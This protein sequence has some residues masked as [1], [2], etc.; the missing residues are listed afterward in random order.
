MPAY[1]PDN[2]CRLCGL[3]VGSSNISQPV[4]GAVARFCC[5]GCMY[6][7]QILYNR[8][9]GVPVDYRD[10]E[11]YRAC[12]SAGII[13]SD[14]GL[15]SRFPGHGSLVEGPLTRDSRLVTQDP[16]KGLTRNLRPETPDPDILDRLSQ[17]LSIKIE[18][19]WCVACSWL[20]EQL[21]LKM[22]GVVSAGI[23]FFSDI[24]H[25]KYMPH[26]V[27]PKAIM[28]NIS[29]LGYRASPI[30]S[31]T[32]SAPSG[33]LAV[34]LGVSAILSMN[35]M[36]ITFALWAGFFEQI[37]REGAALFS[38]TLFVIA[39]P[40]VFYSGWPILRG[41][42]LSIR[43]RTATMD[44]LLAIGVLSAYFYSVVA[45]LRGSLHVYFDTASM[46]VTL[47]LLGRFIETRA[48]EK[49]SGTITAL[50]HAA[51]R[52]VRILMDGKEIWTA[53][54]RV[55]RGDL[56]QV[57]PGERVPV[58]GRIVSGEALVD[59][60]ILTGEP[61]P[62]IKREGAGVSAGSILL[63]GEAKFEAVREGNES[64]LSWKPWTRA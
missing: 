23:F 60:S 33:N 14:Q 28:E 13:P 17:D 16:P 48:K 64:S 59:E 35:I 6:V 21:V 41:A 52:K 34:R 1:S 51:A 8:P 12:V 53:P 7:F 18:G 54:D 45:M 22:E 37:G 58:D 24:A 46:L 56:F 32:S 29:R 40:V 5:L 30:E 9:G 61:L 2:C 10:T 36:M 57:F 19:M 42:F 50:F 11:L 39:T 27:S 49:I 26:L 4:E 20:I 31:P 55:A 63:N 38:Y 47:L 25:I 44:T 43:H 62:V 3:P 15:G